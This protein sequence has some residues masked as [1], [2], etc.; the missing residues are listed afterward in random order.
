[1]TTN[2][3]DDFMN[4]WNAMPEGKLELINGRLIISSLAGSRRIAW[5]LLD[6]YGPPIGLAHAPPQLWWAALEE[7]GVQGDGE[8]NVPKSLF[9]R[10]LGK[11]SSSPGFGS[12]RNES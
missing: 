12:A 10:P 1:M 6:D 3:D 9:R 4:R 5:C 2:A 11:K 8:T 7:A